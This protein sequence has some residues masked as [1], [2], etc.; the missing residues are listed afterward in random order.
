MVT[1]PAG[2]D[3]DLSAGAAVF[4][5]HSGIAGTAELT[6]AMPVEGGFYAGRARPLATSGDFSRAGG[7]VGIVLIGRSY[8]VLFTDYLFPGIAGWKHYLVSVALIP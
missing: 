6:T 7:T 1:T 3:A 8:A 4:L 5:V 2:D